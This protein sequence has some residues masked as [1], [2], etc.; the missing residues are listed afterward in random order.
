MADLGSK[1]ALNADVD[2]KVTTNGTNANTGA[3]VNDCL[4]NIV[5]TLYGAVDEVGFGDLEGTPQD[6]TSLAQQLETISNTIGTKADAIP[7]Y[8]AILN[9]SGTSAPV[10]SDPYNTT[11]ITPSF[12]YAATGTYTISMVGLPAAG[13]RAF[14]TSGNNPG[15]IF[16]SYTGDLETIDLL[17]YNTSGSPANG[18]LAN[19]HLQTASRFGR[20]RASC[21]G[22]R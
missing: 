6:N 8:R 9:Q 20:Y 19:A 21:D 5:D 11:G 22:T 14:V 17:T 7:T 1:S 18:I 10:D 12:A 16:C 15:F 4:N 13:V 2:A 3:R